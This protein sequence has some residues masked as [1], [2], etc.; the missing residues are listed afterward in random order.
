MD[1]EN[2][3]FKSLKNFFVLISSV[4]SE[5]TATREIEVLSAISEDFFQR[6]NPAIIPIFVFDF[7]VSKLIHLLSIKPTYQNRG[8]ILLN[9]QTKADYS[10]PKIKGALKS[11]FDRN[12]CD[13]SVLFLLGHGNKNGDLILNLS[14]GEGELS[15]NETKELWE[16][17]AFK[18]KNKELFIII[19]A[20]YS[21][22]WVA[23]NKNP[24]I[25]IQ[26]SCSEFEKSKDF[27]IQN[28]IVGSV[29]L[30]NFLMLQGF[31]DG[32][33]EVSN[34]NPTCSNLKSGDAERIEKLLEIGCMKKNW[35]EF[36]NFFQFRVR[37]FNKNEII[38]E[39]NENVAHE[40]NIKKSG[41]DVKKWGF[42]TG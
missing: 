15:F 36:L 13:C 26:A 3:E 4:Q 18:D 25:F 27:M 41:P 8:R 37:S 21:G 38:Y 5:K 32:F 9:T 42:S 16:K 19:D 14:E 17:R 12:D 31:A 6:Y 40:E 23:A 1:S 11:F 20:S 22:K 33:Y 35:Q 7:F 2:T 30:H 39:E 29:F 28:E 34:Q 24:D 10:K